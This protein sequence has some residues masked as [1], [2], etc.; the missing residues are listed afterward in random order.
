M[1][2]KI[3]NITNSYYSDEWYTD[4]EIVNLIQGEFLDLGIDVDSSVVM[5]PFD[6]DK[7]EFFKQNTQVIHNITDFIEGDY[8]YDILMTN[9][10]FS[11]KDSVIEKVFKDGKPSALILPLDS[12]GGVK[13]HK[14]YNQYHFPYVLTPNRRISYTNEQGEKKKGSSMHSIIMFFN[15]NK[16]GVKYIGI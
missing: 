1:K 10:P 4:K 8:K 15:C 5:C 9:P 12:M 14:M 7:S 6:S 16:T 2:Q 11:I 13:R 3:N